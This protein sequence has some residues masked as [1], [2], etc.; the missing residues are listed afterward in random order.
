[1]TSQSRNGLTQ[2]LLIIVMGVSGCG[3]STIASALAREL[4]FKFLEA[5]D[6]HSTENRNHMAAGKPLTDSMRQPWINAMRECI[7]LLSEQSKNCV[8]SFSGLKADHRTQI[9]N[10]PA[11][12]ITLHLKG[13]QALIEQRM[14]ARKDHF[15]PSSLLDSQF[16]ALQDPSDE[17]DTYTLDID[18]SLDIINKQA[19]DIVR[20]LTA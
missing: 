15:M 6:F 2:P 17:A 19:L 5:D 11:R 12:N 3:K 14:R 4:G 1:M 7:I 10:V 9:K 16:Q 20:G 8:L 13:E 18:Q